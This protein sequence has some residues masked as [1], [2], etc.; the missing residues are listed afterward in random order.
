MKSNQHIYGST[1]TPPPRAAL[2]WSSS[3]SSN[4]HLHSL[5]NLHSAHCFSTSYHK[6]SCRSGPHDA[7]RMK[8]GACVLFALLLARACLREAKC[9]LPMEVTGETGVPRQSVTGRHRDDIRSGVS[10]GHRDDIQSSVTS[11]HRDGFHRLPGLCR[12]LRRRRLSYLCHKV[13]FRCWGRSQGWGR[14]GQVCRCPRGSTCSR[15]FIR[16]I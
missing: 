8:T 6:P 5:K 4:L 15:V 1:L 11:G 7:C 2:G 12:R 9:S 14:S 10:T 13:S 3:A 16:S